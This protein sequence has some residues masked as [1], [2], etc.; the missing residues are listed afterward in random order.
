MAVT[1][2]FWEPDTTPVLVAGA[3]EVVGLGTLDTPMTTIGG[4]AVPLGATDVETVDAGV[5]IDANTED[6][7]E[8]ESEANIEVEAAVDVEPVFE[9]LDDCGALD[10]VAVTEALDCVVDEAGCASVAEDEVEG[11]TVEDEVM[12]P[13]GVGGAFGSGI[14]TVH[15]L[16]S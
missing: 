1:E 6:V 7:D 3:S 13:E 5:D 9:A 4:G 11:A 8:A 16:T 2:G 14:V 15:V 12:E 10:E